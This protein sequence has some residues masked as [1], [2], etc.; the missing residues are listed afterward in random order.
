[1]SVQK[2]WND[3]LRR[4]DWIDLSYVLHKKDV[5]DP[6]HGTEYKPPKKKANNK[7]RKNARV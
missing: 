1:M 2:I 7:R 5:P 6:H 4:W 3:K